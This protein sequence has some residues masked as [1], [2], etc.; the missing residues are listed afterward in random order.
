MALDITEQD[1]QNTQTLG[2]FLREVRL[3]KGI[4]IDDIVAETRI[5]LINVRAMEEDDFDTL[6]SAAFSRGLYTIYAKTL[7]LDVDII[8]RRFSVENEGLRGK[9]NAP[10]TP[11]K[12][13]KE[14]GSMAER[15]PA[16]P[17]SLLGLGFLAAVL[18]IALGCWYYSVNPATYLSEKL[19]SFQEDTTIQDEA[20]AESVSTSEA[21]GV[22]QD[23]ASTIDN[24]AQ[25]ALPRYTLDAIFPEQT[26]I[27]VTLDEEFPQQIIA[28]A[29]RKMSWTADQ[30][31]EIVIPAPTT[32][33]FTLNGTEVVLPSADNGEITISLPEYLFE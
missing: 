20:T 19:R 3:E 32:A 33:I 16:P 1:E 24:S 30:A 4:E 17:T 11:S 31:M 26:T 25:D 18:I 28:S 2:E 15:P 5:S 29:G 8:L 23:T 12:L 10:V 21:S 7:Q 14:I 22:S 13:V 27:K 6:P 9:N